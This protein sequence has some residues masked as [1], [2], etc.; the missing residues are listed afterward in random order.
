MQE[1]N[2]IPAHVAALLNNRQK[3]SR[4]CLDAIREFRASKPWRGTVS[5]RKAK[6]AALH[7][8]LAEHYGLK[9]RLVFQGVGANMPSDNSSFDRR[10]DAIVLTGR[11]SVVTY[12]HLICAARDFEVKRCLAWSLSLFKRMFPLSWSRCEFEGYM[13]RK[14]SND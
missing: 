2:T 8:K 9:T 1:N 3:F 4:P 7:A 13:I 11:L 12:L 6:F 10:K 14:R 5:E